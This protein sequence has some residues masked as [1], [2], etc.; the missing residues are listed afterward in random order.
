M[1]QPTDA[2][3]FYGICIPHEGS[4]KPWREDEDWSERYARIVAKI[5]PPSKSYPE[6]QGVLKPGSWQRAEPDYTPEEKATVEEHRAY[7]ANKREAAAKCPV[8]FDTHC[9]GDYPMPFL[10]IQGTL[11]TANRGDPAPID[12]KQL[13]SSTDT[14]VWNTHLIGMAK[15]MGINIGDAKPG[16]WLASNWN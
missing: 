10:Y 12:V 7:W 14:D 16:W 13:Y 8:Q 6:K 3:L 9:S 11:T 1:G 5:L 4:S 15:T 2:Y